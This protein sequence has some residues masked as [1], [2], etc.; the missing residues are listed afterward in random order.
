[1]LGKILATR[2]AAGIREV[3]AGVDHPQGWIT[4]MLFQPLRAHHGAGIMHVNFS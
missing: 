2:I 1:M 3:H 4:K